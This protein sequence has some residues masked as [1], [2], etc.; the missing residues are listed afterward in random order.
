M[1]SRSVEPLLGE[2]SEGPYCTLAAKWREEAERL[3]A[4]E[5]H[6]QAA[7]LEVAATE[8]E[9]A[10]AQ[11]SGELLT[12]REA[13][14]ESGYGEEHLRRLVRQGELPAQRNGGKRSRIRVRRGDLPIKP[15]KNGRGTPGRVGYDPGEDARDIA[16]IMGGVS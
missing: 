5:A 13:A 15:S 3:R 16:R 10:A 9:A 14:A 8:L 2:S 12:I 1:R 4:L 6:G 11:W 7:A